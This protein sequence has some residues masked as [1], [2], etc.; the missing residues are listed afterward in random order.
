[1]L[2]YYASIQVS[3][4]LFMLFLGTRSL[5]SA[6]ELAQTLLYT[7]EGQRLLAAGLIIGVGLAVM[8]FMLSVVSIPL[9]LDRPIDA[10]SA[11]ATSL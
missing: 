1:M 7:P 8:V 10:V 3:I 4:L 9:M 6:S 5:P 2:V 11:M